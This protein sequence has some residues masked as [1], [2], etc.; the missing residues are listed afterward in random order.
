MH[1]IF[2]NAQE[3][4]PAAT[5]ESNSIQR[6]HLDSSKNAIKDAHSIDLV[7]EKGK[8]CEFQLT[9]LVAIGGQATVDWKVLLK[10]FADKL[11]NPEADYE[12]KGLKIVYHWTFPAAHKEI[13]FL[14]PQTVAQT[15]YH[16]KVAGFYRKLHC[17]A[18][19]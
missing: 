5:D 19:I 13:F 11:G 18:R 12:E 15:T 8:L 6:W 10:G 9:Y 14:P 2:P 1:E 7:F 4:T 17:E 3:A 16:Y